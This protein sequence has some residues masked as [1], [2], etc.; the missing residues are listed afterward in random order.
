MSGDRAG[1]DRLG[2]LG[3]VEI[4]GVHAVV[5]LRQAAT[6]RSAHAAESDKAQKT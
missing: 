1:L 6:H 3:R 5:G 2:H 4:V